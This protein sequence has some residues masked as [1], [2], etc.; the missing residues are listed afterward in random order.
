MR[1]PQDFE[2]ANIFRELPNCGYSAE[3]CKA[4][5]EWYHR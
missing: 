4:I 3:A 5:F 1:T 2:E